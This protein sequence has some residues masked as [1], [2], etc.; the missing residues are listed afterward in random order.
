M[1]RVLCILVFLCVH[2]LWAVNPI[3]EYVDFP[4]N[5]KLSFE[6][7]TIKTND[8]FSLKSWVCFANKAKAKNRTLVLAYGDAGNMSYYLRQ[9]VE[10]VNQ[11]YNVVLFDYRGFGESD[12]FLID[13]NVLYYD[14]FA[15]D[16]QAVVAYAK[17]KF[18][19]K[20]GVW[21]LSMGTISAVL[22]NDTTPLDYLI[23]DGFVVSPNDVVKKMDEY[24]QKEIKLPSNA[25]DYDKALS[26]LSIPILF[27]AGDRDGLTT[28]YDSNK[29][30]LLN[31]KSQVVVYKGGHLQGFQAMT[32]TYHG[33][34]YIEAIDTFYTNT[35]NA[36]E[37]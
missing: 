15:T 32:N 29:V 2:L 27:F 33:Q 6:E 36:N 34:G 8:G 18:K 24:L 9:T 3:K 1:K 7:V 13:E 16:L 10:L 21:A 14:E 26:R 23:A 11:G 25:R 12:N 37:K 28:V 17:E 5:S 22:A 19:T 35:F 31:P 4:T 20:V 30:K